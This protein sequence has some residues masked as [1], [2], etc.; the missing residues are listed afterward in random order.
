[1]GGSEGRMRR[2]GIGQ[3]D[4]GATDSNC[5]WGSQPCCR[6]GGKFFGL[7]S[8]ADG[9]KSF[10]AKSSIGLDVFY[11]ALV[12]DTRT[13]TGNPQPHRKRYL[14]HHE[15]RRWGDLSAQF[16]EQEIKGPPGEAGLDL[17]DSF[18]TAYATFTSIALGFAF[19]DLGIWRFSTPSLKSAFTFS[20]STRS[21]KV[22]L[23]TKL[24]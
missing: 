18:G 8:C 5:S 3:S 20:S 10:L 4:G 22:K 13:V 6:P 24:P 19:S 17:G 15:S 12:F 23:R 21:G 1:M 2:P 7:I 14:P 11:Q 16:L 9:E